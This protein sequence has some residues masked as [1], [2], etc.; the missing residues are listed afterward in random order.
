MKLS[1]VHCVYGVNP[2]IKESIQYNLHALQEAKVNYEY[3]VFNDKGDKKVV[4][5]IQDLIDNKEITYH[6]S[7]INYGEGKCRGGW[8]GAIPLCSGDI[9]HCIDDDDVFVKEF[10]EKALDAFID[11]EIMFFTSNF[12]QSNESLQPTRPEL[13]PNMLIDYTQPLERWK[14]WFGVSNEGKDPWFNHPTEKNQV[15]RANNMMPASGTI[16]RIKLHD[17]IGNPSPKEFFGT[18]DFEYWARMLFYEN[19]G[20]Y[21]PI[22]LWFHRISNN[23]LHVKENKKGKDHRPPYMEKIRRKYYDLWEEKN[24]NNI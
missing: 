11:P 24:K 3:I 14:E 15:T 18:C 8:L 5:D 7:N 17:L 19:K 22:P 4:N 1:L 21:N 16:Y 6:Y 10:Y 23:S 9:F 13:N 2:Y 20:I 12:M